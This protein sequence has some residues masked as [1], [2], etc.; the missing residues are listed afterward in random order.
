MRDPAFPHRVGSKRVKLVREAQ[1]TVSATRVNIMQRRIRMGMGFLGLGS[2]F[3]R[4]D[5]YEC[6]NYVRIKL[7]PGHVE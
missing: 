7:C 6:F 5:F 1:P 2:L 3:T 4:D